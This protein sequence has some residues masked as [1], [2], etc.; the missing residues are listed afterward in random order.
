MNLKAKWD[1]IYQEATDEPPPARVLVENAHLLPSSGCALDLAC[2]LG[3]NALFLAER[4]FEVT[5][6]DLSEVA[7]EKLRRRALGWKL[8]AQAVDVT[9]VPWPEQA[10]DVIVV[11]RFLV[12]SLCS[13]IAA[14]LKPGGLLYYQTFV[15]A[16][17]ASSG[18]EN[19]AYLL[20]EN[21]L[22]RLFPGLIVRAFRDEGRCGDLGQGFRNEAYLVGERP[23]FQVYKGGEY[24]GIQSYP[25]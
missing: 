6:W 1:R 22:L 14:A 11:S 15:R 13:K 3:S 20:E 17:A 9:A 18:P 21:E 19:P 25:P 7:I 12:R 23:Q 4:G 8:N 16:K 24:G 5:A 10:F 2:G